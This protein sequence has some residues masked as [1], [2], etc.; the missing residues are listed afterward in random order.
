MDKKV[1]YDDDL[2]FAMLKSMNEDLNIEPD[3]SEEVDAINMIDEKEEIMR[4]WGMVYNFNGMDI[5]NLIN[6]VFQPK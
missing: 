4:W 3:S 1:F 2:Y 6:P 5:K